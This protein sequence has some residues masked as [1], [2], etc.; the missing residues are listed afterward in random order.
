VGLILSL[1]GCEGTTTFAGREEFFDGSKVP[2]GFAAKGAYPIILAHGLGGTAD[3]GFNDAIALA[4]QADGFQ[5][6]KTTVPAVDGVAVR[7]QALNQQVDSILQR[8]GQPRVH[9]I[10]HSMGGLDARYVISAMNRGDAVASLTT[11]STPHAGSALADVALGLTGV[12]GTRTEALQTF[13]D[14]LGVAQGQDINLDAALNDLAEANA[15]AFDQLTQ[16]V[17][18]TVKYQ[19][20]AG[21]SVVPGF[22]NAN[23][24]INTACPQ[25]VMGNGTRDT[26][27]PMLVLTAPTVAHNLQLR[28]H[29]GV[30]TVQS[31]N[32]P[33]SYGPLAQFRGC[34][35]ADHLDETSGATEPQT[36]F[37]GTQ[38][39]RNVAAELAPLR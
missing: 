28:P 29:D 13:A 18:A 30:V 1:A 39:Y 16:N 4:L 15:P 19:A 3:N 6:F 2:N 5:V 17:N 38:F 35:P 25:M 36:G 21:V 14:L 12:L 22:G 33:A 11:I 23:P 10:A 24:N 7:G 8:T 32:F 37:D 26:L 20:Y 31:A 27:R 9:I 34:I